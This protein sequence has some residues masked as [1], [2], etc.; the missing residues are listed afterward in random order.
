MILCMIAALSS[1]YVI[2]KDNKLPRHHPEDLQR[3]KHI[4]LDSPIIMGKNT[5][6]SIWKPLPRRRNIVISSK[7]IFPEVETYST[8]DIAFQLLNEEVDTHD[9]VY[10]IGGESLY[11][12]FLWQAEYLYLTEIKKE[13]VWDTFFPKFEEEFEEIER[14]PHSDFDFVT[15][16]RKRVI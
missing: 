2:W 8:P 7:T 13:Y 15:Y 9:T 10:V 12:Y 4:T 3:F 14:I 11:R 1:N 16:R 5:Y 6:L